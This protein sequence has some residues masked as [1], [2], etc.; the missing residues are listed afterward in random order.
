MP[1]LDP[2]CASATIR[3]VPTHRIELSQNLNVI[4]I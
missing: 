4:N 3:S 1:S 2:Y